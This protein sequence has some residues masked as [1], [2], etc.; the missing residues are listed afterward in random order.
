MLLLEDCIRDWPAHLV[1]HTEVVSSARRRQV[2][3]KAADKAAAD[4]FVGA[5][6]VLLAADMVPLAGMA[7]DMAAADSLHPDPDRVADRTNPN[8]R[9]PVDS[10]D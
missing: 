8:R 3:D 6:M 2:A 9:L 4:A 1:E 7:V 10:L 5:D